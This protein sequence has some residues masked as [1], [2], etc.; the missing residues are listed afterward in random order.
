MKNK[1]AIFGAPPRY[2]RKLY[3]SR[4]VV[5]SLEDLLPLIKDILSSRWLTNNGKFVQELEKELTKYLQAPYCLA[6]TNGTSA[7]QLSIK[8]LGLSGEVITTPFTFPA[9]VHVLSWNNITPVFCDVNQESYNIDPEKIELHITPATTGILPVHT[10]GNPC[11]VEKIEKIA[12]ANGLAVLY[13][14]AHAF[15]VET[16]RQAIGNYGDVSAFSFH[17]TK[18]FNTIE[19]GAVSFSNPDLH[20]KLRD[21]RNFGI[22]SEEEVVGPGINAKMNE[23]QAAF[24]ILNLRNI[25]SNR[26]KRKDIYEKYQSKLKEIPGLK[27]QKFLPEIKYNYAYYP[28]EIITEEFGLTRDEVYKVFR[29]EGIMVRK[30][31]WPLASNYS[32]YQSLP[33]ADKYLLPQANLLSKRILILPLYADLEDRD[34]NNI[35]ELFLLIYKYSSEIKK[36]LNPI[37]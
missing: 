12:K 35:I 34:I 16:N 30:Y 9:T 2:P 13:D 11:E 23:I 31:F 26:E 8:A 18:I 37:K 4:P 6:V 19:G 22:R 1:L 14:A 17:A 24:G 5:P 21:L 33:S 20:Q 27:F 10:F 29:A 32:C 7:L 3:L 36:K 28:V 15:G 25:S